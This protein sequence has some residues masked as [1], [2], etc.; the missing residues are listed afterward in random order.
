M[1]CQP[2]RRYWIDLVVDIQFAIDTLMQFR[3]AYFSERAGRLIWSRALIRRHVL[4]K[5]IVVDILGIL[6]YDDIVHALMQRSSNPLV[7][8]PRLEALRL[9]RL[10]QASYLTVDASLACNA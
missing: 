10:F 2:A 6:R 1:C 7:V 5:W 8:G 4:R 3:I 9:L